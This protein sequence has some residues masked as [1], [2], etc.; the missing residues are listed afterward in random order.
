MSEIEILQKYMTEARIERLE[1]AL[2]QRT[3]QLC[4]VIDRLDKP[5]N[6]MAVM[7]TC[8]AFGIQDL[9]IIPLETDEP[10]A[11]SRKITQ[12]AH[13]WLTIHHHDSWGHC[14]GHLRANDYRIYGSFLSESHGTLEDLPLDGKIAL[15]FGNELKGLTPSQVKDCDGAFMLPM[16]GLSQSFNI[17]VACALSL[18]QIMLLR[19]HQSIPLETLSASET[20]E[21]RQEW[22][23]KAVVNSELYLQE[24]RR[25]GEL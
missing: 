5:H 6:Y 10:D 12:G 14:L 23:R 1:K 9:H 13:K 15:V 17:S 22:Y 18:Q 20:G 4:V 7:R 21:L 8:D 3:R 11:V 19:K 16:R 25:R 2:A 24:A